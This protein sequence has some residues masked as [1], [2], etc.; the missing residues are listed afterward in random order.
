MN[1]KQIDLNM[2]P[3][4]KS[5]TV[6]QQIMEICIAGITLNGSTPKQSNPPKQ[7]KPP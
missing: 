3:I 4:K 2:F 6:K 1:I 7:S 5:I